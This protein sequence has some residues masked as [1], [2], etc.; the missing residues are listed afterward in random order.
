MLELQKSSA[1]LH[2]HYDEEQARVLSR[3]LADR[4]PVVAIDPPS[5]TAMQRSARLDVYRLCIA[6]ELTLRRAGAYLDSE[7]DQADVVE[8][9]RELRKLIYL[10]QGIFGWAQ[11]T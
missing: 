2:R 1:G 6:L 9:V 8:H 11:D 10:A 3:A 7:D 4:L 5:S